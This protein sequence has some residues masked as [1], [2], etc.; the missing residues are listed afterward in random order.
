MTLAVTAQSVHGEFFDRKLGN[1]QRSSGLC[2]VRT[3][4]APK[5]HADAGTLHMYLGSGG[6]PKGYCAPGMRSIPQ[7][8]EEAGSNFLDVGTPLSE[9]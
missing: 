5:L 8:F 9:C 2:K 3:E 6:Y 4:I 1:N 7:G